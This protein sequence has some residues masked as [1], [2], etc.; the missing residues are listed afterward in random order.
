MFDGTVSRGSSSAV[1]FRDGTADWRPRVARNRLCVF[2][3][4]GLDVTLAAFVLVLL[5]PAYGLIA[6]AIALDSPGPILF[7]QQRTGLNGRVFTIYK[8]R[9]MRP[10]T[11][12]SAVHHAT[13]GDDRVTRVG[14]VL[15]ETSLDEV[16]QLLNILKG[17]MAI[18]GPRPHAL[19]HDLHYAALLP[20]YNE[21]F[22]VRPG[23]TGLAQVQG[24]RGEIRE[25]SCMAR[26]VECDILY[27]RHWSFPGDLSIILR[28][29]PLLLAR[30][31]AY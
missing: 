29:I 7:R 21:R 11:A 10:A 18:V 15:R 30:V 28:T 16:P 2:L 23:L 3:K 13:R 22:A 5:A 25:L 9:T 14:R 1:S 31:N 12:G 17:D 8:F 4:R 26:R 24:L 19:E 20:H 6:L 27:A